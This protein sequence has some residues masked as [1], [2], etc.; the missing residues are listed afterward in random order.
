MCRQHRPLFGSSNLAV[1]SSLCDY[2][3]PSCFSSN[4]PKVDPACCNWCRHCPAVK[5]AADEMSIP[6]ILSNQL[7]SS[8]CEVLLLLP[9]LDHYYHSC[10]CCCYC[11]YCC[12]LH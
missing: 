11:R 7:S 4:Q 5:R 10:C 8:Q 2:R 3:L 6:F 12:H 1:G 9:L